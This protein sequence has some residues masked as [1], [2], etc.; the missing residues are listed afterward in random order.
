MRD[1]PEDFRAV[2]LCADHAHGE[3]KGETEMALELLF[4]VV[5]N[6]TGEEIEREW[7]GVAAFKCGE[8]ITRDGRSFEVSHRVREADDVVRVFLQEQW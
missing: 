3:T 1:L 6:E 5:N 7:Y 8:E 4:V 2:A